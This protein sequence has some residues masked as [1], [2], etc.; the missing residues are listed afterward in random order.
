[1][2]RVAYNQTNFTAGEISPKMLGRGDI[3]RYPNAVKKMVNAFALIYGGAKRHFGTAFEAEVKNSADKVRLMPFIFSRD[4]A[5][6][7]EVGPGYIRF[8]NPN[9]RLESSGVP[10]EVPTPY[11]ASDLFELEYTQGADSM[12]ITTENVTPQRLL[13]TGASSFQM[14]NIPFDVTPFKEWGQRF[15]ATMSVV[16][17]TINTS[18]NTFLVSDIGRQIRAGSGLLQITTYNS[19]TSVSGTVLVN[20]NSTFYGVFDWMITGSPQVAISPTQSKPEGLTVLVSAHGSQNLCLSYSWAAGVLTLNT[21]TAHGLIPADKVVLV[22][23]ESIGL[24]GTY[25]VVTTP[26]PNQFT[27]NYSSQVQQGGTLGVIYHFGIGEAWRPTDVGSFI[28]INGGLIR[29]TQFL[30]S[31]EVNGV[32]V[33][34]MTSTIASPP[35]GWSLE[36]L[37][38]N[39]TDGYPRAVALH[40]QRL[41]FAGSPGYPRTLWGS[42][43][44]EYYNFTIGTDDDDGYEFELASSDSVDQI[45]HIYSMRRLIIQT[46]GGEFIGGGGNSNAITPTNIQIDPQTAY[47]SNQVKPVRVG[48]ELLFVQRSGRRIR[49]L[50]YNFD[51]DA[52]VA[53]DL[54]RLAEHI[55]ESGIV[56][57]AYQQEPY[58]IVWAVRADGTLLSLT[59]DRGQQV[60]GWSRKVTDGFVESVACIPAGDHDQVWVSVRRTL[61]GTQ[62]RYVERLDESMLVDC[63]VELF[64]GSPQTVWTG[65]S[66]L[67]GRMVSVV[68]DGTYRGQ[69]LVSGGQIALDTS[70]LRVQIGLFFAPEIQLLNPML[71][72]PTGSSAIAAMNTSEVTVQFLDTC[73]CTVNG[74]EMSFREFGN[75]LL[76]QPVDLFTGYKRIENMDPWDRGATPVTIGQNDCMPFQVLS[77]IRRFTAND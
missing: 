16:G 77:V 8:Y 10:V 35:N 72:T 24:D 51:S 71:N 4:Q 13:R 53:D 31:T 75:D 11:I 37:V 43:I 30:N 73:S 1:M 14:G 76:D 36:G 22:G 45:A 19:P 47:G 15:N 66:H 21:A 60:I 18:S 12:F 17:A 57:M 52:Y 9:G 28:R 38:W 46:F 32:I 3:D 64:S 40:Q 41:I 59:Y 69:Y 68:G 58:T 48:S 61:N 65:L 34:E 67:N 54:A 33:K 20:F 26:T 63:G 25:T 6:I 55:T 7:L 2:V 29:I 62:K 70:A 27:I 44:G 39:T 50:S 74:Q 49:A 23:F 42:R 56:D 5:Y